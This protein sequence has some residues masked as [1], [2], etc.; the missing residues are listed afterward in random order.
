MQNLRIPFDT[1]DG[2]FNAV[3]SAGALEFPLAAAD[4][5]QTASTAS[6]AES[7]AQSA[8]MLAL[9]GTGVGVLGLLAA[10]ALWLSRPRLAAPARRPTAEHV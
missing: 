6:A 10:A 2:K 1:A 8:R 3:E 4:P 7:D 5:A 9:G